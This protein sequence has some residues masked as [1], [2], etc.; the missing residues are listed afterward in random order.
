MRF[1][2]PG[3]SIGRCPLGFAQAP[4]IL[5]FLGLLPPLNQFMPLL[6]LALIWRFATSLQVALRVAR[7][8]LAV[9]TIS[10]L[11]GA[12]AGVLLGFAVASW[13]YA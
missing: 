3:R 9:A 2:T 10:V 4:S 13:I 8:H 11:A 12:G 6:P 5:Y 7:L 1:G